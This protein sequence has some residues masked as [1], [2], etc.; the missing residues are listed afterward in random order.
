MMNSFKGNGHSSVAH[1]KKGTLKRVLRVFDLFAIGYSD[2]G[3]SI[4]YALGVTALFALGATPIALGLAGIVFICT[5]LTYAEMTSM[6]QESG[7]SASFARHAFNDLVSFIAGW[8][9][10]LDY[11]VTIAISAFSVPPYLGYFFPDLKQTPAQISFTIILI[12]ILLTM[13]IVGVKRSTRVSVL[14]TIFTLLVQ[15]V[16]ISIGFSMLLDIPYVIDHMRIGIS[17]VDWSPSWSGFAKG[18]AMAMVAYTGIESIAQLAAESQHAVKTVPKA[19]VLTLCVLIV[20]Y[21]GISL[22]ALSAVSPQELGTR[23]LLDPVAAIVSALPVGKEILSPFVA[24]LAAAILTVAS[25]AGLLG[26]SRLA[27]NL[28]EHY[29]LPRSF[30][31]INRKFKTPIVALVTF[32]AFS[33]FVIVAS[34]GKLDFMA[35][36]YNFG[37]MLAFLS[38]HLSLIVM[39]IKKPSMARPFRAP[40][41]ISFGKFSIPLT[42]IIGALAT[43]SV[44][45]LVV[46]EKPYGRYLGLGWMAFG[47]TMYV[48]YR[49]KRQIR[50]TARLELQEISLPDLRPIEIKKILVH[51][52][53]DMPMEAVQMACEMAKTHKA[54]LCALEVLEISPALPLDVEMPARMLLAEQVLKQAEAIARDQGVDMELQIV[55]SRSQINTIL[56]KLQ[57]ESYDLLI[58]SGA[59][60]FTEAATG[61]I[62]SISELILRKAS[63]RVLVYA[64]GPKDVKLHH[65]AFFPHVTT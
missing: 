5:A 22:V 25:N 9:L 32:A 30:Y 51:V 49:Q 11:I 40:L 7:G 10:L 21:L 1:L 24:V 59:T 57:K 29:Q 15:A 20:T 63:C 8:G 50:P 19:I 27:F 48:L 6:F 46:I 14:I 52:Y 54:K 28:G 34:R 13:N 31:S 36:L 18:T 41:N 17:G 12:L 4:Y 45:C 44:W 61:K 37:A 3:S 39:R 65:P 42:A 47:I 62:S 33:I 60:S 56:E 2:L 38:A 64:A 23:F 55:R 26:A 58:L 43:F 16:V 53:A 35:D